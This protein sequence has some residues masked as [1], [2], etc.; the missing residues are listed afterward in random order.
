MQCVFCESKEIKERIIVRNSLV[1]AFP[2]NI[3]IVPGHLLII[4][5]RCVATWEQMNHEEQHAIV[6]LMEKLK[7]ILKKELN[8]EGFHVAWNEGAVAGQSVQHFH[9]HL[10]PRKEGDTGIIEYEPRKFIYRPGSRQ[11]SPEK[12]LEEISEIIRKALNK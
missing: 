7:P 2:T 12:E 4:P 8:T 1:C 6:E 5:I 11:A 9:L 3:P 10:I